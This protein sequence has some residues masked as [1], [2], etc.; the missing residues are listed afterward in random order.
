MKRLSNRLDLPQSVAPSRGK[1]V[2][3]AVHYL[4][5]QDP[6]VIGGGVE[7]A[8]WVKRMESRP[9]S[10]EKESRNYGGEGLEQR[11]DRESAPGVMGPQ[12]TITCS[13]NNTLMTLTGPNRSTI[14]LT[15]G[16][17][18]LRGA[19]RGTPYAAE[20]LGRERAER[21]KEAGVTR[22]GVRGRGVTECVGAVVRRLVRAYLQMDFFARDTAMAHGG[23]RRRKA[24]RI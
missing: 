18:K 24:R 7:D 21:C 19:R 4:G 9:G 14:R 16:R 1:R 17:N 6:R 15:A 8:G 11:K 22:F 2:G 10:V 20:R 23:T 5:K 13:G 12:C 3:K